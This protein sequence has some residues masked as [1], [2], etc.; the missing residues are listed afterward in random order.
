[1]FT[2]IQASIEVHTVK[3]RA[4]LLRLFRVL[5]CIVLATLLVVVLVYLCF[6]LVHLEF[7]DPLRIS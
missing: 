1:M 3:Q 4:Q 6:V 5:S 2:K 7:D